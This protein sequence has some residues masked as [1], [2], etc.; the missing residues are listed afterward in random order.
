M[1][2][3]L[4]AADREIRGPNPTQWQLER[5]LSL[6][7]FDLLLGGFLLRLT[8]FVLDVFVIDAHGLLNLGAESSLI[9]STG[10]VS[11]WIRRA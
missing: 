10:I 1:R 4:L 7:F 6:L 2:P 11:T 8:L 9:G 3:S 5:G